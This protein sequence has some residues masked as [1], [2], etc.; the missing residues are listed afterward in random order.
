[1]QEALRI[2]EDIKNNKEFKKINEVKPDVFNDNMIIEE[3]TKDLKAEGFTNIPEVSDLDPLPKKTTITATNRAEDKNAEDEYESAQDRIDEYLVKE[4]GA[5]KKVNEDSNVYHTT[6]DIGDDGKF[7][8]YFTVKD[9]KI[10]EA[11]KNADGNFDVQNDAEEVSAEVIGK[12]HDALSKAKELIDA[13]KITYYNNELDAVCKYP[14]FKSVVDNKY[15][16]IKDNEFALIEDCTGIKIVDGEPY[17]EGTDK[18]LDELARETLS[19]Q[20]E[21]LKILAQVN[22]IKGLIVDLM[23][24]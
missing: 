3:T 2:R 6:V 15:F 17:A 10:V 20:A 19:N 7:T 23:S 12:Y 16:I 22:E 9:D 8:R 21:N 18:K 13:G 11:T 14:I 1:M 4:R 5:L 24:S